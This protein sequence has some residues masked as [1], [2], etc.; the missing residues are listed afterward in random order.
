[1]V[2]FATDYV[3]MCRDNLHPVTEIGDPVPYRDDPPD[4]SLNC[5][6]TDIY[7]PGCRRNPGKAHDE[8]RTVEHIALFH[9][10]T[11]SKEDFRTKIN[12]RNGAGFT[13]DWRYFRMIQKCVSSASG[14]LDTA[15]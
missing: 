10:V 3:I 13:R 14:S 2:F 7:T 9:Y 15:A 5:K 4:E 6:P 1:M 8:N 12:R 11:K